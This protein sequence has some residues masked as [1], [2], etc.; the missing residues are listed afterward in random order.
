MQP[1]QPF[2]EAPVLAPPDLE[3]HPQK[4]QMVDGG[5][6]SLLDKAA[7]FIKV[8]NETSHVNKKPPSLGAHYF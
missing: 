3:V 8:N 2:G 7:D 1:A 5:D 6:K 4:E